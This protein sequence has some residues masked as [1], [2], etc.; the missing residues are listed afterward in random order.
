MTTTAH[1][2]FGT[3]PVGSEVLEWDWNEDDFGFRWK[4]E[5]NVIPDE[6]ITVTVDWRQVSV[7]GLVD[8]VSHIGDPADFAQRVVRFT[9]SE[10]NGD[11]IATGW[12]RYSE[13]ARM[14]DDRLVSQ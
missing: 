3:S 4:S 10:T 11:F 9:V 14:L 1:A 7:S 6:A 8:A 13:A 2:E 5:Y 12:V